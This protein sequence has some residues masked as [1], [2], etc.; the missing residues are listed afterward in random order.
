MLSARFISRLVFMSFNSERE[1]NLPPF[2]RSSN[3]RQCCCFQ[4]IRLFL[5]P[6]NCRFR[7]LAH[8]VNPNAARLL[9][10]VNVSAHCK[11]NLVKNT[12]MNTFEHKLTCSH[13][14]IHFAPGLIHSI[15][16]PVCLLV[17]WLNNAQ[18]ENPPKTPIGKFYVLQKHRSRVFKVLKI[19]KYL[20]GLSS[21]YVY[22][23]YPQEGNQQ[24][25]QLTGFMFRPHGHYPTRFPG[26]VSNK[27]TPKP[28]TT[29]RI[30]IVESA[31]KNFRN[32]V[33]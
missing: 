16:Q 20:G 26:D 18:F 21:P 17:S 12:T 28:G 29:P 5:E 33:G 10:N 3:P 27:R 8:I 25:Q 9:L 4:S 6:K 11:P 14:N 31:R 22:C 19:Q 23:T 15:C 30:K 1:S 24:Q 13:S 2:Y 32:L 7:C